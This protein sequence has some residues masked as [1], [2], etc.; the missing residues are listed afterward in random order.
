MLPCKNFVIASRI[1]FHGWASCTRRA[2]FDLRW[3]GMSNCDSETATVT[4]TFSPLIFRCQAQLQPFGPTLQMYLLSSLKS[5]VSAESFLLKVNFA[6]EYWNLEAKDRLSVKTLSLFFFF[7]FFFAKP[8][9]FARHQMTEITQDSFDS[10]QERV[11]TELLSLS[12]FDI[13]WVWCK[14]L[15]GSLDKNC[16][17]LSSWQGFVP[18]HHDSFVMFLSWISVN[19]INSSQS[20]EFSTSPGYRPQRLKI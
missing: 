18:W 7:L 20:Q 19:S 5:L 8:I 11:C 9:S 2:F 15:M 6:P 16:Q 3:L 12:W 1:W 13:V 10:W 4:P 14:L 17:K